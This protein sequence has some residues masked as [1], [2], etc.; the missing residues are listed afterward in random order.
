MFGKRAGWGMT[1]PFL[2][3]NVVV[4]GISQKPV[5]VEGTLENREF[6]CLTVSFDHE[7]VDGAPAARFTNRFVE[8]IESGFG[9]VDNQRVIS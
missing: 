1:I 3:I 9:L 7:I 6:L 4:G 2:T 5:L 8:R